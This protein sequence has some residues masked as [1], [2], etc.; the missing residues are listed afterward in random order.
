MFTK[1][2]AKV[3]EPD[4][5]EFAAAFQLSL[6]SRKDGCDVLGIPFTVLESKVSDLFSVER[7][8]LMRVYVEMFLLWQAYDADGGTYE[9]L[10]HRFDMF[11]VF[12]GRNPLVSINVVIGMCA[13]VC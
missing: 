4:L 5:V 6:K 10:K 7:E 13:V 1:G 2:D 12:A 3:S 9:S 11:S 8:N